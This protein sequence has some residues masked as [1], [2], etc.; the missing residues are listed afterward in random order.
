MSVA[1]EQW[2]ALVHI[3]VAVERAAVELER[4]V[5]TDKVE[6]EIAQLAA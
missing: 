2:L 6:V 1:A 3:V 4:Q 5:P